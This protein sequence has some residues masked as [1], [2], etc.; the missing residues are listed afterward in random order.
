MAAF[1]VSCALNVGRSSGMVVFSV[2]RALKCAVTLVWWYLVSLV[3]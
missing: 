2:S 3:R 1:S